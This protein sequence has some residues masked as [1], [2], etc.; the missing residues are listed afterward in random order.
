MYQAV[1][2]PER[3][4]PKKGN[5]IKAQIY[6]CTNEEQVYRVGGAADPG[7]K[8]APPSPLIDHHQPRCWNGGLH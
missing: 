3:Y 4:Y 1:E 7:T 6:R 5:G 2:I 8:S